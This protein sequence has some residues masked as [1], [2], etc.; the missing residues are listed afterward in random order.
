VMNVS[1]FGVDP[2]RDSYGLFS[3][4]SYLIVFGAVATHLRT[5]AQIRRLIWALTVSSVMLGLY[6]IQQ[7]FGID[8]MLNDPLP[9]LRVAMTFGNPVFAGS[10]LLMTIPLTLALWQG[11]TTR[12]NA[13]AHVGIGA[14]LIAVQATALGFTLSRGPAIS[15]MAAFVV[16]LGAMALAMGARTI[17]RPVASVL[18]AMTIAF[19]MGYVPVPGTIAGAG[20]GEAGTSDNGTG[21]LA[22]R[23]STIGSELT[24]GGGLSAR[25]SIWSTAAKTYVSVPW[26]DTTEYP[27]MPSLGLTPLRP[28]IGYGPDMFRYAFGLEGNPANSTIPWHGHNFIVH[29]AIELGLLGVLA[30]AALAVATGLALVRMWLATKRGETSPWMS[31][32]VFA[33]MG[34]FAGRLLDQMVG[35][36]QVSDLTQTWIMAGVVLA[37]VRMPVS[38]WRA[39]ISQASE[40]SA[41]SAA[42]PRRRSAE[43]RQTATR[44][45]RANAS[46]AMSFQHPIRVAVVAVLGLVT[47]VF[48]WQAVLMHVSAT[49]LAASAISASDAGEYVTAGDFL[50]KSVDR[51]PSSTAPRTTLGRALLVASRLEGDPQERIAKFEE[52][53]RIVRVVQDR[54]PLDHQAWGLRSEIM[55]DLV[56]LDGGYAARAVETHATTAAL[57]SGL[58][59]PAEQLALTY[60]VTED[61]E[62]AL[63]VA[64]SARNLAAKA[65]PRGYYLSFIETLALQG[66]GPG[67]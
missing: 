62:R 60:L 4:A 13:L 63:D 33:L 53:E 18:L 8:A 11:W 19:A 21:T 20:Y 26:I 57:T 61:Y 5:G 25:Y 44:G 10:Y 45:R 9:Q 36:A 67:G 58:R 16:L 3:V 1:V 6:G 30:Y 50:L 24:P 29:T 40:V 15:L 39:P 47:L 17:V 64:T 38:E 51:S 48:W 2:G 34:I 37:M 55:H 35:K 54:N 41:P 66:A 42:G 12:Y 46:G 52:A 23:L 7:H 22:H 56:S 31:V 27:E 43:A 65:D 59:P 28:L 49:F 32:I 14:V